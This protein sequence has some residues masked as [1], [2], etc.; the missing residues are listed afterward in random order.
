MNVASIK[1]HL[2]LKIDFFNKIIRCSEYPNGL[3]LRL[4]FYKFDAEKVNDCRRQKSIPFVW[5]QCCGSDEFFSDSDSYPQI[6]S[7]SDPRANILTQILSKYC[8]LFLSYAFLK[9][10]DQKVFP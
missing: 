7:D 1:Q 2:S 6:F 4:S 8:L 10:R 9:F 3:L 5:N